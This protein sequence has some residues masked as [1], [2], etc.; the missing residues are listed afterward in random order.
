MTA[1]QKRAIPSVVRNIL[2]DLTFIYGGYT[3]SEERSVRAMLV[4]GG[5]PAQIRDA[6]VVA[7]TND[8]VKDEDK[9]RYAFGT[10]KRKMME[11]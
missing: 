4:Y 9:M 1:S 7:A 11:L 10:L 8:R 3:E 2:A 5:T 6:I